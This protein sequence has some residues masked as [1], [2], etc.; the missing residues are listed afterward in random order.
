M[1]A[2]KKYSAWEPTSLVGEAMRAVKRESPEARIV[3][4]SVADPR[5]TLKTLCSIGPFIGGMVD[6][7]EPGSFDVKKIPNAQALTEPLYPNVSVL[8]D[9]GD[10]IRL[11]SYSSF[12]LPMFDLTGV[13]GYFTG[14]IA[15]QIFRLM[16]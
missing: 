6:S 13:D 16:G 14:L 9:D 3:A 15:F 11:E 8:L 10:E 4:V 5:P 1:R 2:T 12:A 7:F